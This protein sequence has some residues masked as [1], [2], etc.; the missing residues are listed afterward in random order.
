MGS[1]IGENVKIRYDL[2]FILFSKQ[3]L[4][5]AGKLNKLWPGTYLIEKTKIR[6]NWGPFL[7]KSS[8]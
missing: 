4:S 6:Y 1:D 2:G 8:K 3:K 5:T 7:L